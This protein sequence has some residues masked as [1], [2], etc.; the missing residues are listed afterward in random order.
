MERFL[1]DRETNE[2]V[3]GGQEAREKRKVKENLRSKEEKRQPGR[4]DMGLRASLSGGHCQ[5]KQQNPQR[6]GSL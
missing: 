4:E 6:E 5:V 3:K 1:E 2:S